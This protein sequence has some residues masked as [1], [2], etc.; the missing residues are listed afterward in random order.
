MRNKKV[1]SL[2]M[3]WSN[4]AF[5]TALGEL[6]TMGGGSFGQLGH[7]DVEYQALPK[8]VEG[9]SCQVCKQVSCGDR[10]TTV[11]MACG[12]VYTFG[13]NEYG[14]LGHGDTN[15]KCH[16]T[17]VQT[18]ETTE[19]IQVQCGVC[20]TMA[21]SRSGY[22]YRW[23]Y[24]GWRCVRP[25]NVHNSILVP[26]LVHKLR[27]HNAVQLSACENWDYFALLVDPSPSPIRQAQQSQFNSKDHSDVTFIVENQ[28][29]YGNIQ[30][31]SRKSQYFEAMF[32]SNMR[33][34]IEGVVVV[35]DVSAAVF[36]KMLE[37]LYF[38]DFA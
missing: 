5:V 18:I 23:G 27:Q 2:D 13:S 1:T 34:C 25:K 33:E 3:R 14:Q 8:L 7:G 35:P 21:L 26:S 6:F 20:S 38:D 31:L 11:V 15:D 9:L 29:I 24:T 19:I 16:P 28:P 17:L 22:V 4:V 36:L 10:H 12:R 32:R 30:L 37:Y